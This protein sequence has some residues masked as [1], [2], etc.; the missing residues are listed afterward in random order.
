M[1][2][3]LR[4]DDRVI[5]HPMHDDV[6]QNGIES[7]SIQVSF[8]GEWTNLGTCRAPDASTSRSSATRRATAESSRA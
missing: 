8:D 4:V 2:Y 7:D 5:S 1:I 6:I 3:P